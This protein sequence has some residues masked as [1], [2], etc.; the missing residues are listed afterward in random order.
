[1]TRS[2]LLSLC[3]AASVLLYTGLVF[4]S[5]SLYT[6]GGS[7]APVNT[8]KDTVEDGVKDNKDSVEDSDEARVVRLHQQCEVLKQQVQR[9]GC[10]STIFKISTLHTS[11]PV[12][13]V[14]EGE[15]PR[16]PHQYPVSALLRPPPPANVRV[17]RQQRLAVCV[18]YKAGS[19]TWRYLLSSLDTGLN[20]TQVRSECYLVRV[21]SVVLR[22]TRC[23]TG[24]RSASTGT[25]CR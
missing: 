19:E 17:S 20:T 1:M 6:G 25:W 23:G 18:P 8:V 5:A 15:Y 24:R 7:L 2:R 21:L 12:C 13:Q 16:A 9:G 10:I 14:E 11:T 22:R 4:Y 3:R